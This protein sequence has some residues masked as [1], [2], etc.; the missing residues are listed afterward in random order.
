ME[1][2]RCYDGEKVRV[3]G[4]CGFVVGHACLRYGRYG[5]T[6]PDETKPM[7][8]DRMWP[9]AFTYSVSCGL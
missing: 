2:G 4:S 5:F 3:D 8:R 9:S 6:L 7:F 1:E